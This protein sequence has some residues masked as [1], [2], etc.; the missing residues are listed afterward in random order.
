[1]RLQKISNHKPTKYQCER[2]TDRGGSTGIVFKHGSRRHVVYL[3]QEI[4][5]A[6]CCPRSHAKMPQA[7]NLLE[8]S[9]RPILAGICPHDDNVLKASVGIATIN[10]LSAHALKTTTVL[11]NLPL[12]G[13]H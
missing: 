7:G 1:M 2:R 11:T 9:C 10:A 8:S 4:P 13:M 6:V 12:M 5:E 3:V